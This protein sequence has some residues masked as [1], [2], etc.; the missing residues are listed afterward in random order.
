MGSVPLSADWSATWRV[1][2]RLAPKRS[3]VPE[4]TVPKLESVSIDYG[5]G[6]TTL[7][8]ASSVAVPGTL[9]ALQGAVS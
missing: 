3:S 2:Q 6:I 7:V 1:L 8:G 5:G 9:A 4:G